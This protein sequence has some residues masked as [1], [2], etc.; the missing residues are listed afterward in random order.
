M[1]SIRVMHISPSISKKQIYHINKRQVIFILFYADFNLKIILIYS[2][3][4]T[5]GEEKKG[6][7]GQGDQKMGRW[8][9]E[10]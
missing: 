8:E 7:A 1:S 9:V 4:S 5:K 3:Y 10:M 2:M 6:G